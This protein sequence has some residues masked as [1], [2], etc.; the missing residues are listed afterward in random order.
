MTRKIQYTIQLGTSF[1]KSQQLIFTLV[2]D[3]TLSTE[4]IFI[5]RPRSYRRI[6]S[7]IMNPVD[8]DT[9]AAAASLNKVLNAHQ[10]DGVS[11]RT[12]VLNFQEFMQPESCF[13]A[14]GEWFPNLGKHAAI[15]LDLLGDAE[16]KFMMGMRNPAH[17]LSAAIASGDYPELSDDSPDPFTLKWAHVLRS[18][19]KHCP[20]TDILCWD[21]DQAAVIW[22]VV[23]SEAIDNR[24]IVPA[25]LSLHLAKKQMNSEGHGRLSDYVSSRPGLT[26]ALTAKVIKAFW[27][28]FQKPVKTPA[29]SAIP[30]WT[31]LHDAQIEQAYNDDL[32][33]IDTIEG[34]VR[35]W[36]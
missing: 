30:N 8:G 32:M 27:T 35:L 28:K 7:Q 13:Y 34:V 33:E 17:M 18:I 23:L 21:G 22:P 19:R 5:P 6:A 14:H 9:V 36:V 2:R 24:K 11:D 31:D 4:N 26:P 10:G 15:L 12:F 1:D 25:D 16:V 20:D 3:K 29:T